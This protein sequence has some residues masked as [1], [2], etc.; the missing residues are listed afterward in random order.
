M[1]HHHY[2]GRIDLPCMNSNSLF[3]TV[4][5]NFQCALK[6]LGYCPTMYII[7]E[8]IMALLSLPFF[9]SHNPSKSLIAVTKKRF[10]S[11]SCIA[12]EILPIAQHN[13]NT[14]AKLFRRRIPRY[15]ENN[16]YSLTVFK[17]FHDHSVPL[18]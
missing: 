3:T 4:F 15:Y 13:C 1:T 6:N 10:S 7:L 17:F 12:P 11:S 14:K 16:F 18:T 8:A 5:K 9:C 2:I